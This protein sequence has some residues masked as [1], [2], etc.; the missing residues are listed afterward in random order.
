MLFCTGFITSI[1]FQWLNIQPSLAYIYFGHA[2]PF[3]QCKKRI[4]NNGQGDRT[5]SLR[6]HWMNTLEAMSE[7]ATCVC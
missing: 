3:N 5:T 2:T 7:V 6:I 4:M 1:R